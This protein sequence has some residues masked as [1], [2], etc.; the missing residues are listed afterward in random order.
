[1]EVKLQTHADNPGDRSFTV[2][3][4]NLLLNEGINLW[5]NVY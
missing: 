5:L 4:D 3:F 1:M 2:Y